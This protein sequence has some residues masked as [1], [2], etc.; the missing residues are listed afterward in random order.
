VKKTAL[1]SDLG[2]AANQW[3]RTAEFQGVLYS[4]SHSVK[5]GGELLAVIYK[6]ANGD[7]LEVYND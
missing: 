4:F 7:E 2:W 6:A 5:R 3:P 1:A